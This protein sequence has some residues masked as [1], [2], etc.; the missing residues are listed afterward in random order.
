MPESDHDIKTIPAPNLMPASSPDRP[1]GPPG[2]H[3]I[4]KKFAYLLSAGWVRDALQGVFFI[5]LARHST[6]TYG[7]FMLALE[8]GLYLAAGL[9]VRTQPPPGDPAV[10]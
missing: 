3:R 6:T 4:L 10:P 5:Y 2:Q 9:R 8:F 7:E 1:G